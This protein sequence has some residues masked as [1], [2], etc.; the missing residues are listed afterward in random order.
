[1]QRVYGKHHAD[2]LVPGSNVR[3]K[4]RPLPAEDHD[5]V[6]ATRQQF[7]V[8]RSHSQ[9]VST[10]AISRAISANGLSLR[11]LRWRKRRTA[12]SFSASQAR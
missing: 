1:M 11:F 9:M 3:R 5:W 6:L 4:L 8:R 10:T 12:S 7:A 2:G